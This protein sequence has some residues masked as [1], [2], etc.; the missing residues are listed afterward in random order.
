M[1]SLTDLT[2]RIA[3]RTLSLLFALLLA[4]IGVKLLI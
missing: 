4:G 1:L 3:G 2:Y